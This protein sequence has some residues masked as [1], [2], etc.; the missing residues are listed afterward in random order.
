MSGSNK[1]SSSTS[2]RSSSRVCEHRS[3]H[4]ILSSLR[5]SFR[6]SDFNEAEKE[7]LSREAKLRREKEEMQYNLREKCGRL[8]ADLSESRLKVLRLEGER[9]KLQRECDINDD[10]LSEF[11][12]D[13]KLARER[14]GKAN[15]RCDGLLQRIRAMDREKEEFLEKLQREQSAYVGSVPAL[16]NE[17]DYLKRKLR[18]KEET[19]NEK[20]VSLE[21]IEKR[22]DVALAQVEELRRK[23]EC[24]EEAKAV[25]DT[26]LKQLLKKIN[27]MR[28][29]DERIDELVKKNESLELETMEARKEI[30]GLE[31]EKRQ[32][33]VT[34]DSMAKQVSE[35]ETCVATW[36]CN[37]PRDK[38]LANIKVGNILSAFIKFLDSNET[39]VHPDSQAKKDGNFVDADLVVASCTNK[40]AE[41]ARA[42]VFEPE[43]SAEAAP[44][45]IVS[46][47]IDIIDIE[48][49]SDD[50]NHHRRER[51]RVLSK[52]E[53]NEVSSN[54]SLNPRHKV[55]KL[56]DLPHGTVK[57]ELCTPQRQAVSAVRKCNEKL[58]EE[59]NVQ[60][61][62][63]SAQADTVCSPKVKEL[64]E[65]CRRFKGSKSLVK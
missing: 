18:E 35:L 38:K 57:H 64:L 1:P 37:V 19:I 10:K 40:L 22:V 26:K 12:T 15:K 14:E 13:L 5:T 6:D 9:V 56:N 61:N 63:R 25:S 24:L 8:E 36:M 46:P 52:R 11:A 29:K 32:Q 30:E 28:E 7:L 17:V 53:D 47:S 55:N 39:G 3:I 62:G 21:D 51:K 34:I 54:D 60:G 50:E 2:N 59:G 42:L 58:S 20:D 23:N 31:A 44:N 49:G 43:V 48:S 16:R 33:E 45:K 27:E 41:V 65:T 4:D